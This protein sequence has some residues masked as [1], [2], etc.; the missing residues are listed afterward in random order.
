VSITRYSRRLSPPRREGPKARLVDLE[1]FP[2]GVTALA[3]RIVEED[4]NDHVLE[5]TDPSSFLDI[6]SSSL[7]EEGLV[8]QLLRM[9]TFT[10]GE[11]MSLE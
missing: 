1:I 11:E 3:E 6:M 5:D 9:D 8:G 10:D 7:M 4:G 2:K